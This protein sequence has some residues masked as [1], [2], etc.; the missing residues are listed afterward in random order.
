MKNITTES[1]LKILNN[2]IENSEI[3]REQL[4]EDLTVMGMDSMTFIR[5]IVS[6]EEIFE[7]EIPDSKLLVAEMNTVNKILSVLN[8]LANISIIEDN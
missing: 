2:N 7:C 5:V 1:V 6:M 4:D 8:S 3:T